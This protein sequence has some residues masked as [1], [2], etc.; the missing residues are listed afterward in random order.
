[1]RLTQIQNVLEMDLQDIPKSWEIMFCTLFFF[2]F[3]KCLFRA[4][5]LHLKD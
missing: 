2:F 1:M 3:F 5:N 4:G